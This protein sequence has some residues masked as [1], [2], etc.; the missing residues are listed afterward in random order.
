MNNII[1][2]YQNETD[3]DIIFKTFRTGASV[4]RFVYQMKFGPND[5]AMIEGNVIK[6][7]DN[8]T[9][10]LKGANYASVESNK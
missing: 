4:R 6:S 7:F 3:G 1:V 9:F 2:I 10:T 8:K 5:Y